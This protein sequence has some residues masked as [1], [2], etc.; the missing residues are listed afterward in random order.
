QTVTI[1]DAGFGLSQVLPLIVYDA[2]WTNG[3]IIAYQPELHLHPRAQSRLA[4][5]FVESVK[6][7]NQ[8]FVESRRADLILRLQTSMAQEL[9]APEDVSVFCL[10]NKTGAATVRRIKF[11]KLGSPEG[12]WPV[13][14]LD[15]TINLARELN[16]ARFA[17]APAKKV[18][19]KASAEKVS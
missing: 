16:S 13:G 6:R 19:L 18:E 11:D 2:R 15:S 3:S 4:D 9:I 14:F 17:K 1:A 12:A 8:A 5:M 7:G 10:E